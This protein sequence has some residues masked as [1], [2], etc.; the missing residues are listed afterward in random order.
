MDAFDEGTV[1]ADGVVR[2]QAGFHP[3]VVVV[4]T[5][6]HGRVD[7]TRTVRGRDP[8]G[9]QHRPGRRGIATGHGLGE[10]RMVGAADEVGALDALDD[11][12]VMAQH[13]AHQVLSEDQFLTDGGA[14]GAFPRLGVR[15]DANA[16][17]GDLRPDGQADVAGERPRGGRPCENRCLVIDQSEFDVDRGL[18]DFLVAEGDLVAGVGGPGL[19]AVRQ[20]L[21]PAVEQALVEHALHGPPGGFHVAVVKGH[22]GVVKVHPVRHAFRHFTPG[23]FVGPDGFTAGVVEGLHAKGFDLLVRHQVEALLHFDFHRQTVGVP[24]AFSLNNEA[25][26]RLPAADEVLVGPSHHVVDARFPVRGWRPLEENEGCTAAPCLDGGLKRTFLG[27][28]LQQA[29]FEGHRVEVARRRRTRHAPST[30]GLVF[31]LSP[32]LF[33]SGPTVKDSSP[34]R[35]TD[36]LWMTREAGGCPAPCCC[37]SSSP[38]SLQW[39]RRRPFRTRWNL[40]QRPAAT[41][42]N[43]PLANRNR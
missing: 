36:A 19:R 8:I 39:F 28:L 25:L 22:V 3:E 21:V 35:C 12:D 23:L 13:F 26:H 40:L 6:H 11:L 42:P 41:V 43:C 38:V 20:H 18:L 17:V 10:E 31:N 5:V 16:D 34:V 1:H 29:P 14:T 2:G 37:C 15:R 9:R 7:H 24:A 4:L 27:P 33:H 32:L 30:K